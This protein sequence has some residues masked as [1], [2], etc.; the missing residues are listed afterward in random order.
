VVIVGDETGEDDSSVP[1]DG[2]EIGT[3]LSFNEFGLE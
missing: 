1:L 2:K 3:G